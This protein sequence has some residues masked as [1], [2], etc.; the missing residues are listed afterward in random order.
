[1]SFQPYIDVVVICATGWG[2]KQHQQSD[3][4]DRFYVWADKRFGSAKVKVLFREFDSPWKHLAARLHKLCTKDC[5]VVFVGHSF[6]CGVGYRRF[7]KAWKKLGR[8]RIRLA[9]LIDPVSARM[10]WLVRCVLALTTYPKFKVKHADEIL[11]FRQVNHLA[12]GELI[13]AISATVIQHTFG[14]KKNLLRYKV[15]GDQHHVEPD[16]DHN[17][18]DKLSLVIRHARAAIE[19]AVEG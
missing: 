14:S 3:I 7:E 1:M 6:G 18:I 16:I 17:N 12:R 4:H 9:V 2:V 5:I 10:G 8:P 15:E 13:S 19:I 11:A